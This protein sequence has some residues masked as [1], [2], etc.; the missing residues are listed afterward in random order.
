V[1]SCRLQQGLVAPR[2]S[3]ERLVDQLGAILRPSLAPIN[4]KTESLSRFSGK[5]RWGV[6]HFQFCVQKQSHQ[7][8]AAP[9]VS[10]KS[11]PGRITSALAP[12]TVQ[13]E[14]KDQLSRGHAGRRD[15]L[16]QGSKGVDKSM[17]LLQGGGGKKH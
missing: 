12:K 15:M 3:C 9:G 13:T 2:Y 5:P 7:G 14:Q 10:R 8:L 1:K 11:S 17:L 16:W 4:P 6:I